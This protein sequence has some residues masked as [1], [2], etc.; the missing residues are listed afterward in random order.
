MGF[1]SDC[2]RQIRI[3]AER[4]GSV[5]I[6]SEL[7]SE[8]WTW[9]SWKSLEF[10]LLGLLSADTGSSEQISCIFHQCPPFE[11]DHSAWLAGWLAGRPAGRLVGW[12]VVRPLDR[13]LD[14]RQRRPSRTTTL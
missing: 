6:Y 2:S 10:E 11:A 3:G 8:R 4:R 7:K 14:R 9:S 1:E 13:T 12:L 5:Q